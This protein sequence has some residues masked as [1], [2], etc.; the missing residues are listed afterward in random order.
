VL[1]LD[2]DGRELSQEF[3][4]TQGAIAHPRPFHQQVFCLDPQIP[5][6]GIRIPTGQIGP[7]FLVI[8]NE[9]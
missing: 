6:D 5:P 7:I 9:K 4:V 2:L 8:M 1:D 3:E